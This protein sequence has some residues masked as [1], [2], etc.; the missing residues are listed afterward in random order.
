MK[1]YTPQPI[2]LRHI[3]VMCFG[4]QGVGKTTTMNRIYL[5][6]D[7]V[8]DPLSADQAETLEIEKLNT[9]PVIHKM[10]NCNVA[11]SYNLYDCPG[12]GTWEID[13]MILT[14]T[15]FLDQQNEKHAK[16]QALKTPLDIDPRIQLG[17]YFF[18]P[19]RISKGDIKLLAELNKV[20]CIT[21]VI[22][23]AD[24]MTIAERQNYKRKVRK[25]LAENG[26]DMVPLVAVSKWPGP[27]K[28]DALPPYAIISSDR[29]Y[30]FGTARKAL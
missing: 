3:A 13:E 1:I 23:L 14:V 24:S 28:S 30:P 15:R 19:P 29:V 12:L 2:E 4:Q 6:T 16:N 7:F 22:G 26:I 17:L 21:P 9:R 27:D 18:R 20:M 8:S 10:P 25:L 5:Q 11:Y